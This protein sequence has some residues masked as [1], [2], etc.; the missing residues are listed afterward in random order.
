MIEQAGLIFFNPYKD[1]LNTK[2]YGEGGNLTK[3]IWQR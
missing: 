1:Y 2:K 3:N